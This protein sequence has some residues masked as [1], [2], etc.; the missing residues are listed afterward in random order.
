MKRHLIA[1]ISIIFLAAVLRF[2]KLDSVP[3][4]MQWDEMGYAYNAYS[5]ME[6]GRDEWG[7]RLPLFLKSFGDYKPALLSYLMIPSFKIFGINDFAAKFPTALLGVLGI[8]G[9]YFI[10]LKLSKKANFA[11]LSALILA[12]TPWHIH[13]SKIAF[14]PIVSLS[15]LLIGLFLFI[16]KNKTQTIAGSLVLFLSMYTYNGARFFVPLIIL[17]YIYIFHKNNLKKYFQ[18]N[19]TSLLCLLSGFVIIFGLTIFSPAGS[20]AKAVFFWDPVEVTTAVEEGIYR[21]AILAKPLTRVF[22]N[23]PLHLTFQLADNYASHF[24]YDYLFAN[25]WQ[26]PAFAFPRHG[27]LL[28][29]FLPFLLI[30]IFAS[31]NTKLKK[32]Y[33]VWLILSPIASTLTKGDPNANRSLIMV[34]AIVFFVSQG[35]FYTGNLF[36]RELLRKA[37]FLLITLSVGFNTVLY[38]HDYYNFFPEDSATYWH[39]FYKEAVQEVHN[40]KSDFSSIY[41]TNT[42]TQPY[43][44]FAW[45]NLINPETVQANTDNRDIEHL[46][47]IKELENISFRSIKKEDLACLLIQDNVLVAISSNDGPFFIDRSEKYIN[48]KLL[49]EKTYYHKNRFHPEKATLE[50]YNSKSLTALETEYLEDRCASQKPVD[51]I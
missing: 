43:I 39:S 48:I 17:S 29:I 23:K 4:G 12:I 28:L 10:N 18:K 15:L 40:K 38:A 5:I 21:D 45:Y 7:N 27:H 11:F 41:F 47:G 22:N 16:S 24:S 31:K 6:T 34:P 50:L 35:I 32:F 51:K 3:A 49:P 20:R 25:T 33:L 37:V 2:Y 14:D 8:I 1:I 42:D 19:T 44:F 9:F 30:G 26:T 36:K 46:G 13:Y